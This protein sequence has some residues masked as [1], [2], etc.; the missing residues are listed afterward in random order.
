M[1]VVS[2]SPQPLTTSPS[3]PNLLYYI[4]VFLSQNIQIVI[5]ETMLIVGIVAQMSFFF[6]DTYF[7]VQQIVTNVVLL[8]MHVH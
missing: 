3:F 1:V 2:C 5:L 6:N 4:V 8:V 7:L